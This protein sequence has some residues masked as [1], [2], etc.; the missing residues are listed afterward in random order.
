M[1]YH[2]SPGY[3]RY[4]TTQLRES[5]QNNMDSQ[6]PSLSRHSIL[7]TAGLSQNHDFQKN[8][9]QKSGNKHGLCHYIKR[10]PIAHFPTHSGS[11]HEQ[12]STSL[13]PIA[14]FRPSTAYLSAPPW[15]GEARRCQ[16]L[17]ASSPGLRT[18]AGRWDQDSRRMRM[19][20][21]GGL[22]HSRARGARRGQRGERSLAELSWGHSGLRPPL[23]QESF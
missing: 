11:H 2:Q 22:H 14:S 3:F 23:H 18:L 21:A 10:E 20:I 12:F 1:R 5:D 7:Q 17:A 6:T 13:S 4:F 15:I 9:I 8:K 19:S 16:C